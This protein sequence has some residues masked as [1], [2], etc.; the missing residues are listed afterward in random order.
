MLGPPSNFSKP[1]CRTTS[2]AGGDTSIGTQMHV[3][4][5]I[6]WLCVCDGCVYS[7]TAA[8]VYIVFST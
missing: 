2:E 4:F 5:H 8:T 1:L 3:L 6:E 7:H